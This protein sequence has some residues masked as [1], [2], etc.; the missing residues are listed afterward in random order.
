MCILKQ[1]DRDAIVSNLSLKIKTQPPKL[2]DF[3]NKGSFFPKSSCILISHDF[4]QYVGEGVDNNL[5]LKS[6]PL[7]HSP[8]CFLNLN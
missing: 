4:S 6:A 1:N 7:I 8:L 3:K 2:R 5:T